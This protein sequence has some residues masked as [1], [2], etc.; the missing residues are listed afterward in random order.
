MAPNSFS[1]PPAGRQRLAVHVLA[2]AC[3][4]LSVSAGLSLP[5]DLGPLD[6]SLATGSGCLQTLYW[7]C[8]PVALCP[9]FVISLFPCPSD[10]G[11][12]LRFSWS[13]IQSPAAL[14]I[15]VFVGL[16]FRSSHGGTMPCIGSSLEVPAQKTG[17]S[18]LSSC[19]PSHLSR[20]LILIHTP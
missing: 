7:A 4:W 3:P 19:L 14:C 2:M 11:C 6:V 16:G 15:R 10:G 20:I 1:R 13:S 9:V 18:S 5:F 12:R 17:C 8:G